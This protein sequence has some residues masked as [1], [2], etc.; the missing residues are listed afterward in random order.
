MNRK[1]KIICFSVLMS[2]LTLYS[3]GQIPSKAW[4]DHLPYGHGDR[5]AEYDHRIFCATVDGSLYSYNLNDRSTQKHSKVNGLSDAEI[6]T[7]GASE[8]TN[9]FLIGYSNGNVDLIRNDSIINIPDIKR[10]MITGSKAINNVYFKDQYAYLACGFGI[11]VC[12]L[13]EQEIKETYLFGPNGSQITVNDITSDGTYL[14]VATLEGIYKAELHDPNLLDFNAWKKMQGLPAPDAGYQYIA[15]F[16]G[17]LLT[18][19]HDEISGT[20]QIISFNDISWEIWENSVQDQYEYF[21]EQRGLLIMSFDDRI[22]IFDSA[23]TMIKDFVSYFGRHVLVDSNMGLWYAAWF[24]GLVMLDEAGNGSLISVQGPTY[25]DVGDVEALAGNVW[26][27]AGTFN[28]YHTGYGAFSFIDEKWAEYNGNSIPAMKDFLNISDIAIDPTD[29]SHVVGGSFGYGIAEFKDGQLISIENESGGV[30]K[31][32]TGITGPG[33]L[34]ISGTDID[35]EG[36]IYAAGSQSE[37]GLYKKPVGG[38][39]QVIETEFDGFQYSTGVGNILATREGQIWLL[40]NNDNILVF[41]ESNGV[42]TE[43]R[44]FAVRNQ[45]GNLLDKIYSIAEDHEGNIWIGTNKGPAIYS[46]TPEIF[47]ESRLTAFQPVISRNDGT[48]L[49]SLLLSGEQINDIEV[50]GADRKWIATQR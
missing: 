38:E 41:K 48:N 50:D 6:S 43:E 9:T 47:E 30:L 42:A 46:N 28:T 35:A 17:G 40:F 45:E 27:G 1:P 11:V 22:K 16:R 3:E 37:T 39:W 25:R 2:F 12:D 34:L 13:A 15:F 10:K 44:L 33:Y 23:G 29:P 18:L 31:A 5:L 20:D 7:I 24:G 32:A 26:V 8:S 4:R 14:Y 19:Y 49:G 21:G 36:N